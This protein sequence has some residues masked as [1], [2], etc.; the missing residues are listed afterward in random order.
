LAG[1]HP[2]PTGAAE[3]HREGV[4]QA[5]LG[6]DVLDEAV[7]PDPQ[8]LQRRQLLQQLGRGGPEPGAA[9][10]PSYPALIATRAITGPT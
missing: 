10:D 2:Q 1:F 4:A 7:H 6:G 3:N 5:V 8:G 9:I